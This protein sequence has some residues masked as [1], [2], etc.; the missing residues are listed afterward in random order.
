MNDTINLSE[1]SSVENTVSP[2]KGELVRSR[3]L[4]NLMDAQSQQSKSQE[5]HISTTSTTNENPSTQYDAQL[6]PEKIKEL[7]ATFE[8]FDEEKTGK[9]N[10]SQF[11]KFV[12]SADVM[13]LTDEQFDTIFSHF[14]TDSNGCIT[15]ENFIN[16][17]EKWMKAMAY[18]RFNVIQHTPQNVMGLQKK[19]QFRIF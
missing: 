9:L 14:E 10:K 13:E 6:N 3:S 5:E 17:V 11:R 4:N 19:K 16:G 7:R 18:V 8:Y 2:A 12:E 15:F 1:N